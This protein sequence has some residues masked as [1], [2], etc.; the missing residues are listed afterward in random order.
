MVGGEVSL[1]Q[2]HRAGDLRPVARNGAAAR[3]PR[4]FSQT[5]APRGY[6]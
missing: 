6:P 1:A 5:Q 2:E 4:R 3:P